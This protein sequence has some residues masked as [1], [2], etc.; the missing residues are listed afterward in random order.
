[1]FLHVQE[2]A[3]YNRR[4]ESV[5]DARDA[6]LP[7]SFITPL[8]G[9]RPLSPRT[10][11]LAQSR[12][13]SPTPAPSSSTLTVPGQPSASHLTPP[14]LP[15]PTANSRRTTLNMPQALPAALPAQGGTNR[16]HKFISKI[17]HVRAFMGPSKGSL[18]N[19]QSNSKRTT[20]LPPGTSVISPLMSPALSRAPSRGPSRGP[21]RAASRRPSLK[22]TLPVNLSSAHGSQLPSPL[23]SDRSHANV[24]SG[25]SS[26]SSD[27]REKDSARS[28]LT[29]QRNRSPLMHRT[30]TG[31]GGDEEPAQEETDMAYYHTLT[32]AD[33]MEKAR[34]N[35][36]LIVHLFCTLATESE[37]ADDENEQE[38]ADSR[39]ASKQGERNTEAKKAPGANQRRGSLARRNSILGAASSVLRRGSMQLNALLGQ[40]SLPLLSISVDLSRCLVLLCLLYRLL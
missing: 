5:A 37:E 30:A 20:L 28:A 6:L 12:T 26:R 19:T 31:E 1:M 18:A 3:L 14:R 25:R 17:M 39:S 8:S 35:L 29:S 36:T 27:R 11:S 32:S 34:D 2:A 4:K 10:R 23:Q 9:S 40:L 33:S 38:T 16:L 22:L 24:L 13:F 7:L 15:L 21:S